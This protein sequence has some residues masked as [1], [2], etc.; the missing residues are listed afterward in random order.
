MFGMVKEP[1]IQHYDGTPTEGFT[2]ELAGMLANTLN[3]PLQ[4]LIAKD[5]E[6]LKQWALDGK[7]HVAAYLNTDAEN[8]DL[9]QLEPIGV[10]P[11]WLV[12]MGDEPP[13]KTLKDLHDLEIHTPV[14]SA[15]AAALKKLAP[16]LVPRIVEL[17]Q[18]DEMDIF[19]DMVQGKTRFAAVDELY[20]QYA[21]NTYPELQPVLKIPGNRTYA[22][23]VHTKAGEAFAAQVNDFMRAVQNDGRLAKLRD[24]YFG[25][26]QRLDT[27]GAQNFI[28]DVA[29]KLPRYKK[30][31]YKA[32]EL[33]GIDWRQLAALAYQ[34]SK[35]DPLA[36]SPTGVRG[37]MMLTEGTAKALGIEDRLNAEQSIMGG[38]R[39]LL[40]LMKAIPDSA[41]QPDRLWL[42]LAAYNVGPGH[43]QTGR[44]L[45][46]KLNK[47]PD[48]WFDMKKV[49]PLLARPAYYSQFKTGRCR[50]GEAVILVENVRS[51]YGILANMEP[52]YEPAKQNKKVKS[53]K[54]MA[55]KGLK[56]K[57]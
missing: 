42:G 55:R 36:T 4:I 17:H 54:R 12:Q 37:M 2:H 19:E 26:I 9:R 49:M 46:K 20:M 51:Y 30:Y 3:V 16:Q 27:A 14:G 22:W 34:E 57:Q 23:A 15:A 53:T 31:F 32:Q 43:V 5:Y 40:D 8:T 38:S 45:A 13:P 44:K 24:T 11:L 35:W 29:S 28:A 1:V 10:R 52:S 7:V 21:S 25:Y 6:E 48:S 41:Q 39:Y 47:N 18:H 50:G 56:H 33:T